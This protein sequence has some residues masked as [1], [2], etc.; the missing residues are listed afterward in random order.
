[1][2]LSE[3]QFQRFLKKNNI[4]ESRVKGFIPEEKEKK[5]RSTIEKG[6]KKTGVND[7]KLW[8]IF[9]IYVRLR[10]ADKNGVCKC[11]TCN[12]RLH[13]SNMQCGHGHGRQFWGTKYHEKNNHAQCVS[14]N[15]FKEGQKD[16]YKAEVD[17]RYGKGTWE[18]LEL[19]NKGAKTLSQFE[20]D[21]LTIYYTKEVDQLKQL[22]A[23]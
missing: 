12:K 18:M 5:P 21:Q 4:S 9:S 1:M 22:K 11:I 3:F 10:D 2:A 13:W 6:K 17:K 8:K 23:A 20:V 7:N 15:G 14:C 19:K 16:K